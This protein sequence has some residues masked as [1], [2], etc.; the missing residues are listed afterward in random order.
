MSNIVSVSPTT[1]Y[2]SVEWNLG[3]MCNYDCMYCPTDLHDSTSKPHS[4][5]T[6][7]SAWES[8]VAQTQSQGLL[9]KIVFSGG[10]V[11]ANKSFLPF[12]QWLRESYS[13][14]IGMILTTTNGSASLQYYKRLAKLVDAISFSTHSE[15]FNEREFFEKV[16]EI[17]KLMTRPEKSVHV[18]IMDEFWNTE[19]IAMYESVLKANNV[20]YSINKINYDWQTRTYPILQGTLNIDAI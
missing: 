7:Q 15:F 13:H 17:D 2:F 4:L 11:T 6:L 10:E 16:I 8:I 3:R 9:Y 1:E 19:R 20:S 18:N 5:E 12:V 14:V